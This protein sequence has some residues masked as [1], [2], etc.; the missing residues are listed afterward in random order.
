M[1]AARKFNFDV[2]FRADSDLYSHAARDRQKKNLSQDE[3]DRLCADARAEGTQTSEVRAL[4]AVAMEARNVGQA[5]G[6]AVAKISGEFDS[7]RAEAAQIALAIAR[8]LAR[9]ALA[10]S[11]EAEVVAALR[12]GMHQAI[13]E[14]RILLRTSPSVAEAISDQITAIAHDEG[15]EGRVQ[16]SADASIEGADCR[17][18]WRGGGAERSEAAIERVIA[19]LIAKR[20]A[21]LDQIKEQ[22]DGGH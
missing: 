11:P 14:P 4:E 20:F 5:V 12:E 10:P 3:L 18:E 8:K 6:E 1:T 17:I 9:A 22:P 19:A 21:Q 13:G 15:Y 7:I 16:I 2:E